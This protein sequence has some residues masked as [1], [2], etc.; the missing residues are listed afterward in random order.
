MLSS[1]LERT[2]LLAIKA[3]GALQIGYFITDNAAAVRNQIRALTGI[4]CDVQWSQV[5]EAFWGLL[6]RRMIYV[7]GARSFGGSSVRLTKRGLHALSNGITI[8]TIA[9]LTCNDC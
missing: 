5:A 9:I 6:A 4:E 8:P 7:G 1:D 3:A 2:L